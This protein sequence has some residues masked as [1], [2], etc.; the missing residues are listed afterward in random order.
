[1]YLGDK[2]VIEVQGFNPKNIPDS[3]EVIVGKAKT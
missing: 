3:G 2:T 1:L